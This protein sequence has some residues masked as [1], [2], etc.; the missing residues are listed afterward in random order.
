MAAGQAAPP[1]YAFV[2]DCTKQ[3]SFIRHGEAV[4]NVAARDV[5]AEASFAD[6]RLTDS[7]LTETG[8]AQAADLRQTLLQSG[9]KFD[10]VIV[11]PLLR[12]LQTAATLFGEQDGQPSLSALHT[13]S[14]TSVPLPMLAVEVVREAFGVHFSS[15]RG[16]VSA[17][18]GDFPEVD[19]SLIKT[20]A[21]AC[22]RRRGSAAW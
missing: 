13:A 19:F 8:L 12:T 20:D 10:L 4:H 5:G 7:P 9:V 18:Q 11:S 17:V 2:A 14:G 1:A 15:K 3:V 22:P 16:P 6:P 21:G